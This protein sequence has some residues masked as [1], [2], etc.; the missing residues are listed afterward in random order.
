M[1]MFQQLY[2][3]APSRDEPTYMGMKI[4]TSPY[5]REFTPILELSH[6]VDVSNS[7]RES[8]DKWLLD[9]FGQKRNVLIIEGKTIV[10]HPNTKQ[11]LIKELESQ[12]LT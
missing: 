3:F 5:L 4:V 8:F 1:N 2:G 6:K 7:F 11:L 10:M 9:T 12:C